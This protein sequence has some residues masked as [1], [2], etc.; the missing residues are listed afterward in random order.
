MENINNGYAE[1]VIVG[2]VFFVLQIW[3]VTMT[4]EKGSKKSFWVNNYQ[5]EE[6]KKRLEKI[7]LKSP[8][9]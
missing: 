5:S 4:L 8:S 6:M 2:V 9:L 7:F 3:W 1:L